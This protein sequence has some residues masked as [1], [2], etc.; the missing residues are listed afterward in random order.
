MGADVR[1]LY[2]FGCLKN[3]NKISKLVGS[4]PS[5]YGCLIRRRKPS[6]L[7]PYVFS[8]SHFQ[9]SDNHNKRDYYCDM[10]VIMCWVE[11]WPSL[12]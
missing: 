8:N 7:H 11:E 6:A 10:F 12:P 1:L 4:S 3:Q 5:C 2:W 9:D